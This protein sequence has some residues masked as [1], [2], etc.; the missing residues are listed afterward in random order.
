MTASLLPSILDLLSPRQCPGCHARLMVTER[1]ACQECMSNISYTHFSRTPLDNPMA[2]MFWGLFDI[3]KAAALFFY[4]AGTSMA[5][6]IH[7]LKYDG[8]QDLAELLGAMLAAELVDTDFV[9]DID[10]IVPVPLTVQRQ[11]A[12]GYNQSELMAKGLSMVTGLPVCTKALRRTDF[13][14]SQ[15]QLNVAQRRQNVEHAFQVD[16][17]VV[18][19]G[20]H[21]L[22]VDDVMTTGATLLACAT[23]LLAIPDIR[24]S[25]ATLGL[26]K[27]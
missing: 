25:V 10:A 27:M 22:L 21:I 17:T 5:R 18:L 4:E 11:R 1:I 14:S 24:I 12:R 23:T 2:R 15:T 8:R 3:Q 16:D 13:Q 20:K 7:A 26:A 9:G 6:V 19:R